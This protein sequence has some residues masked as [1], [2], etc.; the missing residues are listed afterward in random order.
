[1][2]P[3]TDLSTQTRNHYLHCHLQQSRLCQMIYYWTHG[4]YSHRSQ[5]PHHLQDFLYKRKLISG[6]ADL[7]RLF[8]VSL[9]NLVSS[10]SVRNTLQ[11]KAFFHCWLQCLKSRCYPCI[12]I[13]LW[14]HRPPSQK[15]PLPQGRICLSQNLTTRFSCWQRL[16][17]LWSCCRPYSHKPQSNSLYFRFRSLQAKP[18]Q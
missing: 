3:L 2:T 16:L 12:H 9:Q 6:D 5:R 7:E 17:L 8:Q 11:P 15:K 13:R 14:K 4:L 1:M 18:D 10:Q